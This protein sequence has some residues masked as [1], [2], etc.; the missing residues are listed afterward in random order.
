MR[1]NSETKNK[2]SSS[3]KKRI[4]KMRRLLENIPSH[5]YANVFIFNLM[6]FFAALC[7]CALFFNISWR[8]WSEWKEIF[9]FRKKYTRMFFYDLLPF[10]KMNKERKNPRFTFLIPSGDAWFQGD[11]FFPFTA[12]MSESYKKMESFYD[13][14]PRGYFYRVRIASVNFFFI[15]ELMHSCHDSDRE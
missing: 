15:S 6:I 4:E 1:K 5:T 10:I 9:F 14:Q 12:M 7:Y 13:Q 3:S 8:R 2:I 11:P